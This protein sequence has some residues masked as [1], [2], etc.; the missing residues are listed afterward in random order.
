MR[1]LI[2][3]H[4]FAPSTGGVETIVMSLAQG[5]T[6]LKNAAGDVQFDVT[7]A[8]NTPAGEFDDSA[9]PF[10]VIR[11]PS[12]GC[13]WGLTRTCDV[14]H[15]AGP[16]LL[17]LMLARVAGKP[18]VLEHHGFQ[19]ICPNGQL[20]IP[21]SE[22]P[23][24]GHFMAGHHSVC[25][26]CNSSSGYLQSVRYWLLT[27]VRR[28]LAAR[29]RA[30]LSPTQ[31]LGGL[32]QLPAMRFVAHGLETNTLYRRA[33]KPG[34]IVFQGRL[35]TTKGCRLLLD[36]AEILRDQ[37][38]SFELVVIG[39][40]P[41]RTVMESRVAE[42]KLRKHVRFTGR[43]GPDRLEAEMASA[44]VVVVPSLAGEVFGLVVAENMLRGIPVVASDLG[45]FVEVIGTGGRTFRTG[46][47]ADLARVLAEFLA[48]R[49]IAETVGQRGRQR[50]L[51]FYDRS[52]MIDGHVKVYQEVIN[53][54]RY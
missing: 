5:L 13:L 53:M 31:W 41:E 34:R 40:G 45:A 4:F 2:Y 7:V 21:A 14:V 19:C 43:I 11:Q 24:P 23:C 51:G 39:D 20:L 12:V 47:R 32:L 16:A 27:F 50:V 22:T 36:A 33:A 48:D 6:A 49:R 3:S 8:T 28:F 29:V 37:H 44:A 38:H 52:R 26:R 15:M 30:N 17:P 42:T 46:C 54:Y 18:V 35:V 9:L 10:H 1:L 25:L